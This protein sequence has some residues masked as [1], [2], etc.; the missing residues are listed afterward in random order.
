MQVGSL[1][2]VAGEPLPE[3]L[4][5]LVSTIPNEVLN[6]IS[7]VNSKGGMWLVGGAVREFLLGRQPK[8][9]DFAVD[10]TPEEMMEI[11]PDAIP[12]G[13]AF[14]TVTLRAGKHLIEATTLRGEGTYGDG[15]RPDNVDYSKSLGHDLAR[16]DFTFNAMAIDLGRGL[17][18]DPF[19]GRLDLKNLRLRSVGDARLRLGED[20]LRVMRAYR[21]MDLGEGNLCIPDMHLEKSLIEQQHMLR[22]VAPERIWSELQRILRG[23]N[24]GVILQRM[25]GDGLLSRILP[26]QWDSEEVAVLAQSSDYLNAITP[27]A[28]L[29]TLLSNTSIDGLEE[30]LKKCKISTLQIRQVLNLK[31]W[32]R[33]APIEGTE[34]QLRVYSHVL[35]DLLGVVK[36]MDLAWADVGG[37]GPS[38]TEY[39]SMGHRLNDLATSR[40]DGKSLA[41]GNWIMRRTEIQTG[42]RLGALKSWLH[43]IQIERNLGT[44]EEIEQ[45]LCTL[46]WQH[47]DCSKWPKLGWARQ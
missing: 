32:S 8:D 40:S 2:D 13:I 22:L 20:G 9:W 27:M 45:V 11:F 37:K 35:G 26:G 7:K 41:N 33:C 12:T 28:R 19:S 14:G 38:I 44:L 29:A 16:R 17:L 10:L 4:S 42:P 31:R 43:R 47:G 5:D 6:C 15:R 18:H 21:F 34:G 30:E 3:V 36:K 39:E 25:A 1:A 23:A 46:S 24:A